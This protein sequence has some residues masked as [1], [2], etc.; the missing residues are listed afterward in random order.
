MRLLSPYNFTVEVFLF[1]MTHFPGGDKGELLHWGQEGGSNRLPFAEPGCLWLSC[2]WWLKDIMQDH[3][4]TEQEP[5][6]LGPEGQCCEQVKR[7]QCV[8]VCGGGAGEG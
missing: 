4:F 7:G 1:S 5:S 2:S 8:C 6:L 3:V